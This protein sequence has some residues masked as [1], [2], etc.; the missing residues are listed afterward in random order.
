MALRNSKV[1]ASLNPLIKKLNNRGQSLLEYLL[2][3]ALI[4]IS[5]VSILRVMGHSISAKFAQTTKII[6]GR[7]VGEVQIESVKESHYRKKD[8]SDFMSGAAKKEANP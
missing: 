3:T 1:N 8:M 6:Q 2:L 5:T 7:R 4:A